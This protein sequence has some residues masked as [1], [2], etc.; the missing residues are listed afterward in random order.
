MEQVNYQELLIKV[1]INPEGPKGNMSYRKIPCLNR[2][3][4]F[5]LTLN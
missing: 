1:Y 2:L 3:E 5:E 4:F